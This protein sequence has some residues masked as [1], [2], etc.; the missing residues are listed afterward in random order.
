MVIIWQEMCQEILLDGINF[1]IG[2]IGVSDESGVVYYCLLAYILVFSFDVC[3]LCSGR[4]EDI[5]HPEELISCLYGCGAIGDRIW[6]S[7]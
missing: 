7:A 3:I 1:V 2:E 5:Y 6:M 4:Q